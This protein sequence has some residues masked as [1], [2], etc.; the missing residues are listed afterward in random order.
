MVKIH[1]A[2][3]DDEQRLLK[4]LFRFATSSSVHDVVTQG[5][6]ENEAPF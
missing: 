4:P 6:R 5:R 1:L 3:A 2:I